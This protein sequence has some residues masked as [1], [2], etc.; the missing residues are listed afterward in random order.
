[1]KDSDNQLQATDNYGRNS[2]HQTNYR[3]DVALNSLSG[4]GAIG[5]QPETPFRYNLSNRSSPQPS[6]KAPR[7]NPVSESK[8]V[9]TDSESASAYADDM[10]QRNTSN[11][12]S[13]QA[14]NSYT[15]YSSL[16]VAGTEI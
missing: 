8:R 13:S 12:Y 3:D 4:H 16:D 11:I 6:H 14:L 1:M 7:I 15:S 2:G 9:N 10:S 5:G